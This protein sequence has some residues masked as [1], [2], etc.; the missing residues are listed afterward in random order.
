MI[1][2]Y[3]FF[4]IIFAKQNRNKKFQTTMILKNN[5]IYKMDFNTNIPNAKA[6]LASSSRE[7]KNM[8]VHQDTQ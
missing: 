1:W 2:E 7:G 3:E 4:D 5:K 8:S 6:L